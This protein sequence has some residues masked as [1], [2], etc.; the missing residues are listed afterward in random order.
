MLSCLRT[1]SGYGPAQENGAMLI[2]HLDSTD[3]GIR[4]IGAL[5][6][7]PEIGI[8]ECVKPRRL[9]LE[10]PAATIALNWPSANY[11]RSTRS[12]NWAQARG[13]CPLDH[14]IL[15][16]TRVRKSALQARSDLHDNHG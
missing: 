10:T 13:Q 11:R 1:V 8:S 4:T 2:Q 6:T 14:Q 9:F 15:R 7:R 5:R 12:I 16:Y 3:V